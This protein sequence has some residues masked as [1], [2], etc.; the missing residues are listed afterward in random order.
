MKKL[1][2]TLALTS[3]SL[4]TVGESLHSTSDESPV[5]QPTLKA[6]PDWPDLIFH[7]RVSK[8]LAKS[9]KNI[10][11]LAVLCNIYGAGLV[12]FAKNPGGFLQPILR[13]EIDADGLYD[14]CLM[15]KNCH[16]SDE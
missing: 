15:C 14:Q 5:Q 10:K 13:S 12:D 7:L 6:Q 8:T 11:D 4:A 3:P 1:Q 16:D 9:N 2:S